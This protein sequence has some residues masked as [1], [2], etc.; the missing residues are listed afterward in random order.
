MHRFSMSFRP[1]S[2]ETRP[3]MLTVS[4]QRSSRNGASSSSRRTTHADGGRLRMVDRFGAIEEGGSSSA[5][6]RG[7]RTSGDWSLDTSAS[8]RTSLASSSS[9][10]SSSCSELFEMASSR[11]P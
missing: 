7:Y 5:C 8:P 9:E 11:S 3:T 2:S 6:S 10:P 1:D 4:M